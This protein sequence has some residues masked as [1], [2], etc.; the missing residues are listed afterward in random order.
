MEGLTNKFEL[1]V[2]IVGYN[3]GGYYL[4]VIAAQKSDAVLHHK[5]VHL[6]RAHA[7]QTGYI[8]APANYFFFR[9]ESLLSW[10]RKVDNDR[11]ELIVEI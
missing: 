4:P 6:V 10:L 5:E 8:L 9:G 7:L 11:S 2:R 1:L 3:L